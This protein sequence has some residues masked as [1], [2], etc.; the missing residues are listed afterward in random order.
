MVLH[1]VPKSQLDEEVLAEGEDASDLGSGAATVGKILTADGAGGSSFDAPKLQ[2]FAFSSFSGTTT[3]AAS[4]FPVNAAANATADSNNNALQHIQFTDASEQGTVLFP[5]RVPSG[6]TSVKIGMVSRAETAPGGAETVR[7]KLY[8]RSIPDDAAVPAF[9]GGT[10]M[11]AID[12]PANENWQY[13]QETF[14]LAALGLVAGRCI[15]IE[16]TRV[17]ADGSDTLTGSW[18][19]LE[20]NLEFS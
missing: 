17:P 3:P 8:T 1:R 7:A 10:F 2:I 5:F 19:L 15:Q 12:I 13:D 4:E 16:L 6:V 14:T 9:S 11:A 18:N 20:I